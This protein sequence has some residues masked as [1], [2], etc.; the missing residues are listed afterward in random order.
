VAQTE[1]TSAAP[2]QWSRAGRALTGDPFARLRPVYFDPPLSFSF[3]KISSMLK[4][5]AFW[6]CG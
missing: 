3:A 4:V 1:P 5:A 6:R 2:M